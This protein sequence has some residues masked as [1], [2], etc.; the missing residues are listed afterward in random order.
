MVLVLAEDGQAPQIDC[1]TLRTTSASAFAS[2]HA[3]PS[4]QI[5]SQAMCGS[6]RSGP[7][8]TCWLTVPQG[9]GSPVAAGSEASGAD[10]ATWGRDGICVSED[11]AWVRAQQGQRGSCAWWRR[12]AGWC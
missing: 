8:D 7:C 3:P 1:A 5:P 4:S 10:D 2:Q 12:R 6:T 9:G 11:S